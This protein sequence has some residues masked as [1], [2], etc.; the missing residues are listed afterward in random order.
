MRRALQADPEAAVAAELVALAVLERPDKAMQAAPALMAV[1]TCTAVAAAEVL[2]LLAKMR[3][4]PPAA[5]AALV[6]SIQYQ[7][8]IQHML[9]V[10]AAPAEIPD[11]QLRALVVSAEVHPVEAQHQL[12]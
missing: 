7:E 12:E 4:R 8:Q 1:Q 9:V 2:E 11:Y 10:V 6:C 5:P 3:R